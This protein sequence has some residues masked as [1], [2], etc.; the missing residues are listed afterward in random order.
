MIAEVTRLARHC[1]H[2]P[3]AT[4]EQWG[5]AICEAIK[6]GLVVDKDGV[7]WIEPEKFEAETQLELF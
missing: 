1:T 7:L 5:Q 6:Q 4:K 3:K 2:W